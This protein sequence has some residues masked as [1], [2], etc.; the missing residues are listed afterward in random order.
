VKI[1]C[2]SQIEFGT[3]TELNISNLDIADKLI[4]M[5]KKALQCLKSQKHY[6]KAKQDRVELKIRKAL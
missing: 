1:V 2:S 4:I 6:R 3:N 5:P